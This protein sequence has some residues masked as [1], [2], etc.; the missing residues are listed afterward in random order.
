M[1]ISAGYAVFGFGDTIH[2]WRA[3]IKTLAEARE[4]IKYAKRRGTNGPYR[5]VR[6]Y[7]A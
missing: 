7:P 4:V 5:I 6:V 2:P 1:W 3:G